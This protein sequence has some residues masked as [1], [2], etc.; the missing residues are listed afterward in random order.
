MLDMARSRPPGWLIWIGQSSATSPT[1][2]HSASH[3]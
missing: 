2:G 3:K 1:H